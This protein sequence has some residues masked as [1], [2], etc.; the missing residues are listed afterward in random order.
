MT[1]HAWGCSPQ[2]EALKVFRNNGASPFGCCTRATPPSAL[3]PCSLPPGL[4]F[5]SNLQLSYTPEAPVQEKTRTTSPKWGC[6]PHGKAP[7][8]LRRNGASALGGCHFHRTAFGLV[9]LHPEFWSWFRH[10]QEQLC[11]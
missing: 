10:P 7:Q 3:L 11:R 6:N 5:P 9:A 1:S 4:G 2:R 8:V